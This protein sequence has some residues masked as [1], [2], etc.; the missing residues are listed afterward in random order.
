MRLAQLLASMK[1]ASGRVQIDGFYDDVVPLTEREKQAVAA[2]PAIDAELMRELQFGRPEGGGAS[3][4]DL[5]GQPS[6]NIR[7]LRQ[8]VRRRPGAERGAGEGRGVHRHPARE[9]HPAGAAVQAR[10][11]AYVEK[12]GYFVVQGREPTP[13]ERRA[14]PAVARLDYGGGYPATRFVDGS[15]GLALPSRSVLDGATGGG[16]VKAPTLGGSAPMYVFDR[17]GSP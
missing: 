17:L 13:E 7:G 2:L 12:Q 3:L 16:L 10:L 15:A 8:R 4:A 6:L 5:L 14:H 1:D 11:V 9:G